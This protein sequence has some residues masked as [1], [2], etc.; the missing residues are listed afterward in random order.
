MKRIVSGIILCAIVTT[1]TSCKKDFIRL[2]A[3]RTLSA[4]GITLLVKG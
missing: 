1:L 3:V 2:M 4:N